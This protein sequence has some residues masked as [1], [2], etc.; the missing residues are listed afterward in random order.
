MADKAKGAVLRTV[1]T[2]P[3]LT[4]AAIPF[5]PAVGAG[6]RFLS[7]PEGVPSAALLACDRWR[8]G[9][10]GDPMHKLI[11]VVSGQIDIEGGSGGWLVIPG[12]L[13]FVPAHRPFN[14][15]TGDATVAHV[16]HLD[17][18]DSAWI[19]EGCWVTRANA[20][21]RE[22]IGYA[23]GFEVGDPAEGDAARQFFRT[24]SH[25]CRDWFSNRRMLFMPAARSDEMRAVIAYVRDNLAGATVG[26][27]CAAAALPQRTLHRRCRQEFGYG[28]STLIREVRT[29]RAM[30]LLA[31]GDR[32]VQSVARSVGFASFGSFTS[33]FSRRLGVSPSEF[34]RAVRCRPGSP[35]WA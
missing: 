21:A 7:R 26:G 11:L 18:A 15:A 32:S 14:L 10:L 1:G 13:I 3:R 5:A 28:I 25:L 31:V 35:G 33:A 24:L 34:M 30:E 23:L 17:P 6:R 9:S 19:H 22:M 4:R 29:M 2:L 12:H 20:L 16:A 8:E 27:A